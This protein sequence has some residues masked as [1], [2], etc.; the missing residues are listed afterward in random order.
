MK[1]FSQLS[2]DELKKLNKTSLILI[3]ASLQD[4]LDHMSKQLNNL[5][6]QVALMN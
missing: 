4:Q 5:V 6:E 2:H 3:I 1:N